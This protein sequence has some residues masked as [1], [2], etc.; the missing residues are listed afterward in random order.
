MSNFIHCECPLISTFCYSYLIFFLLG[1]NHCRC[2]SRGRKCSWMSNSVP[3]DI[4]QCLV[5]ECVL[6]LRHVPSDMVWSGCNHSNCWVSKS[7]Y[8][9]SYNSVKVLGG[10]NWFNRNWYYFSDG[11]NT[12]DSDHLAKGLAGSG[13]N[14]KAS[15]TALLHIPC[16][17]CV[18][19][20]FMKLS[21]DLTF[22]IT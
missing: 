4:C 15:F 12:W 18:S 17:F 3:D 10:Y 14:Q 8:H 2:G 20:S 16:G 22:N 1:L 13:A 19:F 7:C 5:R 21:N 9:C 11:S 6:T